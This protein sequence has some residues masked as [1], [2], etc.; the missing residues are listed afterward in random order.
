MAL[1]IDAARQKGGGGL[2]RPTA[3]SVNVVKGARLADSAGLHRA[4]VVLSEGPAAPSVTG[5]CIDGAREPG[6]PAE[7]KV[8]GRPHATYIAAMSAVAIPLFVCHANCRRSVLASYLYRQLCPAITVL[9]A[10]L[11]P[12]ERTSDTALAMLACWGVDATGHQPTK[13]D[14]RRCEEASAIFV[15][16]PPYIR[17]LLLEYGRDLADK[18][19]LYGE[20][21]SRP[22][23]FPPEHTVPDPS[24]DPRPTQELVEQFTWMRERTLHIGRSLLGRGRPLV[25][26]SSYLDLL[27]T[28]DPYG[29]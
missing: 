18:T 1:P 26:T 15:M 21:F 5:H 14:R 22:E 28:V 16:A 9:S 20:P 19:Y 11:D 4:H 23:S 17:R 10:G 27:E 24:F 13:L 6:R 2:P 8:G 7:K 25:A 3:V 12:G 29:H